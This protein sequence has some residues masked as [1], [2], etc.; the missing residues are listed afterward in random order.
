[1]RADR[2]GRKISAMIQM[3]LTTPE[4]LLS[5]KRSL[6]IENSTIR[7]AKNAKL[8]KMNHTMS[9]NDMAVPFPGQNGRDEAW[10]SSRGER[11]TWRGGPASG[12]GRR[13]RRGRIGTGPVPIRLPSGRR[14][15]S[16]RVGEG[17][18]ELV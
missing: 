8:M 16:R 7:Y 13:R 4:T 2:N 3:A 9:Q 18:P 6:T 5:R 17:F 12:R 14:P 15:T 11:L 10:R 1:M